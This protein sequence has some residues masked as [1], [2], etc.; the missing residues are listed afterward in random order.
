MFALQ[1]DCNI[2]VEAYHCPYPPSAL[3]PTTNTT[4]ARGDLESDVTSLDA[5]P[6]GS[7]VLSLQAIGTGIK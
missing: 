1:R 6:D 4:H 3:F 7:A 2:L 5:I